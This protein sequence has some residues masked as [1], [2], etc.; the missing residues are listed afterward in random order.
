MLVRNVRLGS[1]AD[2]H[3]TGLAVVNFTAS[4]V[5]FTNPAEVSKLIFTDRT[6]WLAF[7]MLAFPSD[8]AWASPSEKAS[9]HDQHIRKIENH[10][11]PSAIVDGVS[12]HTV[13]LR[14]RMKTLRV[15]GVSIAFIREGKIAW[16]RGYG[17]TREGGPSVTPETMFQ[18]ASISKSFTSMVVLKLVESGRLSLD[19]DVSQYLKSWKIP[20]GKFGGKVTLRQLLSNTAGMTVHGF[21]GY[22]RGKPVPT[23]VQVLNGEKPANSPAI[24]QEAEPGTAF[25][26][27][28]G[29]YVLTQ[30]VLEDATGVSFPKLLHDTVIAPLGMARSTFDQPLP[31]S[32]R[33]V[34]TP[35]R[36]YGGPVRGGAHTY[37]EMGP[38]GLWSTPTDLARFAI[39]IQNSLAGNP[40]GVLSAKTAHLMVAPGKEI[41][42]SFG[43]VPT[44][45][46][47]GVVV[48]G[49][50]QP[51][52]WHDGE[53]QGF[54]SILVAYNRGDGV[55]IMTNGD[56]GNLLFRDI[57]R[58][59]A[60]EYGWSNFQPTK[61]LPAKVDTKLLDTY[62]GHYKSADGTVY[63]ITRNGDH[64]FERH[65]A[66]ST[67]QLVPQEEHNFVLSGFSPLDAKLRFLMDAEGR[68]TSIALNQN[69][70]DTFANRI[71][72][73][74]PLVVQNQDM[75]R[76]FDLQIQSQG[77]EAALRRLI[78]Q[79]QRGKPE[80]DQMEEI[81]AT[82]V[83]AKLAEYQAEMEMLGAVQTVA[84]R[85]VGTSGN[86]IYEVEYE[87]GW[88]LWRVGLTDNGKFRA[89]SYSLE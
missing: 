30:Q 46:G 64:L 57:L 25:S 23:L 44:A 31:A 45:Y 67:F 74:D 79:L 43:G 84:F 29:G 58:T 80:Y 66:R 7:L 83:K 10:L 86:D 19:L 54:L 9:V 33:N 12:T 77:S 65:S 78:E 61:L 55:V 15:P 69:G 40:G 56:G 68:V 5:P 75:F 27:S 3:A 34:A 41:G 51:F 6:F 32:W 22:A 82:T 70:A 49:G 60:H 87:K 2:I 37:P 11:L 47:L 38:A 21:D 14:E 76:K 1:E 35:Y 39:A 24:V 73:G 59:V 28:G 63:T 18:A 71:G 42:F 16:A 20:P 53:N 62:V 72:S 50:D 26:Y 81:L 48:G 36:D 89:A 85:S 17:L 52:F 8:G 88:A 13:T 4:G